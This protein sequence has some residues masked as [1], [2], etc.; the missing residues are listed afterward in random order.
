MEP[1]DEELPSYQK[2]VLI[3]GGIV[4]GI[5]F[6]INIISGYMQ[7]NA[8]PSASVLM[9]MGVMSLVGCL[10]SMLA[11][12][13][14]TWHYSNFLQSSITLGKGALI[15]LFT[16]IV[17]ALVTTILSKIWSVLNP[18]FNQQL[19]ESVI[20]GFESL[21]L[22]EQQKQ[23]Q[24]D[25]IYNNLKSA[26]SLWSMIKSFLGG[27]V[28]YGLLN[29]LTGMLGVKLFIQRKAY[30]NQMSDSNSEDPEVG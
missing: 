29:A 11:G 15:G 23:A 6:I 10:V 28:L 24:I 1:L 25:M 14:S 4:G 17:L 9:T 13:V 22:P 7:I 12:L 8:E 3:G 16:G 21:D 2:S 20:A 19:M 5:A 26:G 18:D 27:G 30:Q